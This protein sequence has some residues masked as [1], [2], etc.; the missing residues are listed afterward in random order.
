MNKQTMEILEYNKIKG[1]LRTFA[2][3]EMAK[4]IIDQLQPSVDITLI[5][6]YLLETTE[7]RAIVNISASIPIHSLQGMKRLKSNLEKGVVLSPG[8]FEVLYSFIY[9][10][11]KLK[12]FMESKAYI[13][14]NITGYAKSIYTLDAL[15]D[16]IEKCIVRGRVDDRASTSLAK[17][18][19]RIHIVEERIKNRLDVYLRNSQYRE[20]MQD[21]IVSQR[22][23]R[24]VIPVK[25]QHKKSIEGNTLDT[26]SS[27][28][29]VFIE[30]VEIKKL[31]DD[32]NQ[33]KH[34]EE[35]E[36]YK[37]LSTLTALA[38]QYNREISI[39]M[40]TMVHYDFLFAKGKYSKSIEG[41]K[42][43]LNTNNYI[44][45]NKGRHPLLGSIAVPL[46]FE[47]GDSY[48]S[49]V[50]TGPNTGG[51]TVVLK[52]VGLLTMMIQS[53]LHVPVGEGSHFAVFLNIMGDIGDGQ[54]IEQNL[55]TFSSHIKNIVSILA[56]ADQKTMVLLDEIGAG[57]D[58]GEGMGIGIAVLEEL[59]KKGAT[60]V[61]T[62]HYSEIKDFAQKHEGFIN[63]CM[64]F[65]L[66][67]LK[68][69]YRLRIGKSGES[70]AFFIA[71]RLGMETALIERAHVI[72][73]KESKK[74]KAYKMEKIL[75]LDQTIVQDY[76]QQI[77]KQ[78]KA[79]ERNII[80]QKQTAKPKFQIG[81]CVYIS[82]M[83][84]TG[85]VCEQE[86]NRGEV[87][88]M[89]M[90]KKLKINQKRLSIYIE[91]KE[92]YPENYDLDIILESKDIRKKKKI[93][94]RKYVPGM[95][96]EEREDDVNR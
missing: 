56:C 66:K 54:S 48:R 43:G 95:K 14:P 77:E 39:N 85:I 65:D 93:M 83:N 8:E 23:G 69:L 86:N 3:S 72:T 91:G 30:P 63:G 70:N 59:Y 60:I 17:I 29:T 7:A 46:D 1:H 84:K 64:D 34:Q 37:I 61:A 94:G 52:T 40:E 53:G 15:T 35:E 55:S 78:N 38:F 75:T 36:V 62:T 50:I 81:D 89:V 51:K 32:V 20:Y 9:E 73:Y 33:L 31:Q 49:F 45:I 87:G 68:P 76:N 10:G 22:D 47:I 28:S 21:S 24:Y 13:A 44:K 42:A 25:S 80:K 88:V 96:I 58:P 74:Y 71:L 11:K 90:K 82:M 16:E 26:S 92:L 2:L 12:K 4:E 41:T 67:T 27:G 57:T 6:R 5:E 18:R 19:K 79:E